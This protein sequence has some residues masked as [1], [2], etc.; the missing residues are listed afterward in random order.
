MGICNFRKQQ[1][2]DTPNE[3]SEDEGVDIEYDIKRGIVVVYIDAD[4]K[5]SDKVFSLLKSINAKPITHNIREASNYRALRKTLKKLT[6]ESSTPY[7][8]I[9]G[10][11]YGQ[12]T[13]LEKGIKNHTVQKLINSKLMEEPA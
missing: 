3:V 1:H 13:E 11:F 6:G 7:I 5:D 2:F 8:F 12:V 10:K 9:A 4:N